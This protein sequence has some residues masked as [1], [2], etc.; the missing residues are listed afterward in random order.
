MHG[1]MVGTSYIREKEMLSYANSYFVNIANNLTAG[2]Q[3]GDFMP[4]NV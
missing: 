2:P 1:L 3:D 4:P